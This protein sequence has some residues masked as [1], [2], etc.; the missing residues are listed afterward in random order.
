M[1]VVHGGH[2]YY[3]PE[4]EEMCSSLEGNKADLVLTAH[5]ERMTAAEIDKNLV[6]SVLFGS[7]SVL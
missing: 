4:F 1:L 6:Q 5:M 2:A 7:K 3:A